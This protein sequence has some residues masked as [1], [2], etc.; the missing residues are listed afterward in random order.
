MF[1]LSLYLTLVLFAFV[2]C[3]WA[4]I[5]GL[6]H[7]MQKKISLGEF[8]LVGPLSLLFMVINTQV[9]VTFFRGRLLELVRYETVHVSK[10]VIQEY[11]PAPE[12]SPATPAE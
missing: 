4:G 12:S 5:T 3:A 11:L 9:S 1:L 10:A 7:W 2:C 6:V 8:L